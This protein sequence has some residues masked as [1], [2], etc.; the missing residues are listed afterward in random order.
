MAATR[1]LNRTG[2]VVF[3]AL[4]AMILAPSSY[5]LAEVTAE[6]HKTVPLSADGR[7]SLENINGNAEI[8]GWD[9]NEV[10]I[11]A[12]KT[13]PDQQRL[14]EA[15]IE[16]DGSGDSVRI[17]TRYPENRNHNNP[18]SVHY[19]L[20]VPMNAQLE[21]VDLVNG[22]LDISHVSGEVNAN[23]VNG[24]LRAHDLAGTSKLSTVNGSMD[25]EFRTL[26]D[27]REVKLNS[28]NGSMN[29]VLPSSPNAEI[30]A[31]TVS[32]SI[33]TDSRCK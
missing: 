19:T 20:H 18:G 28:V 7:V 11:D 15:R 8:T 3:A 14:D 2:S 33:R 25:A 26:A 24:R 29:V 16:V 13:A 10:Q 21:K 30:R 9:R 1:D 22:S 12:V 4:V 27:V 6:F 31:A 23:L 5:A 32:G 17:R